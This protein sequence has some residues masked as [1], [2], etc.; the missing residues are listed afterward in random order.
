MIG[1]N[2]RAERA[3]LNLSQVQLGELL[4]LS[5]DVVSD[6]ENARRAL[7]VNELP[8][9]CQALGVPLVDLLR[10]ADPDDLRKLGF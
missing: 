6:I 10:R 3:R 1:A 2:V 9:L 7:T 5:G 4:K 8:K